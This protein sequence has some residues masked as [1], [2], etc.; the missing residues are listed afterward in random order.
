MLKTR[1]T[2]NDIS[3]NSLITTQDYSSDR[4]QYNNKLL[5]LGAVSVINSINDSEVYEYTPNANELNFNIYFLRYMADN[6]INEIKPYIESEFMTHI[7]K[8][9]IELGIIRANGS[10]LGA[11][12]N[13]IFEVRQA[14]NNLR[15][16]QIEVEKNETSLKS[17]N[18]K[19]YFSSDKIGESLLKRPAKSGIPVFYNSYT[20]PFW[21]KKN[22]WVKN[23]L[24]YANKP[25]FNNSFM[26]MEFYD[27]PSPLNQNRILSTPVFVN[28][29]YNIK[30]LTNNGKKSVI[31]ERPCFKLKNG[32]DGFSFFFLN[33]F[34]KN[35]FYVKF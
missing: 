30:E 33:N 7:N 12:F 23:D 29:R 26:L 35:D 32:S 15:A 27:S 28:S 2:D 34:I 16:P 19:P 25:Y 14:D 20:I 1:V 17:L 22:D 24:L 10:N 18:N 4:D 9:K 21:S 13:N 11:A 3:V 8:T 31:H 6:E 5:N